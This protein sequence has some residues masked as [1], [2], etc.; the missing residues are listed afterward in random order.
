MGDDLAVKRLD[1]AV[2][3]CPPGDEVG[4]ELVEDASSCLAMPA[5]HVLPGGCV[6][7]A[8]D[9]APAPSEVAGDLAVAVA[10]TKQI[11]D[12]SVVLAA[13]LRHATCRRDRFCVLVL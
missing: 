10:A 11:V 3:G 7:V 6:G 13:P 8:G 12:Q 2:P 9:G 5:K 4:L 1:H